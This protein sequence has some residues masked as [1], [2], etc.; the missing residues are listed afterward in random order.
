[1][2]ACRRPW[3][4]PWSSICSPAP[5]PSAWKHSPAGQHASPPSRAKPTCAE[6]SAPISRLWAAPRG[7]RS[8]PPT[9]PTCHLRSGLAIW[10]CWI[11]PTVPAS[12]RLRSTRSWTALAGRYDD[13]RRR[14]WGGRPLRATG[15][16]H[17]AGP[18][19]L[20]EDRPHLS[21]AQANS[22]L[23]RPG[24]FSASA[25]ASQSPSAA[26]FSRLASASSLPKS[27]IRAASFSRAAE[28]SAAW[29]AAALPGRGQSVAPPRPRHP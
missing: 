12:R 3:K 21:L 15:G 27:A 24:A 5:A 20:R 7:R 13:R 23:T 9:R 11:R 16:T 4:V 1:M 28:A 17:G 29:K 25:A 10:R 26:A 2:A 19:P 6:S 14:A 22:G 18:P 8:S